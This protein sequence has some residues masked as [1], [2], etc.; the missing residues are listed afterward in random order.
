M[1]SARLGVILL[2]PP[3]AGKGSEAALFVERFGIPHISTGDMLREQIR[4]GTELGILAATFI[5]KGLLVP[6]RVVVDMVSDR[7]NRSDCENGFLLDG[8][9]RSVGQ[10]EALASSGHRITDVILLDV[11]EE[12]LVRRITSRRSCPRCGRVYNVVTLP[13]ADGIHCDACPDVELIIR[14][15]DGEATIRARLREYNATTAPLIE[16]YGARGLLKCVDGTGTV[17]E[18]FDRILKVMPVDGSMEE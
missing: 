7:L 16:W 13:S 5:E 15:D 14:K 9:P 4:T 2:G 17:N 1:T 8:F 10:A 3:G 11:D 12:L 18:V 6:D